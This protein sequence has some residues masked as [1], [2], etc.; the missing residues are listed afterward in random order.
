MAGTEEVVIVGGGVIGLSI[1]YA[2]ARDGVS[3]AVLDRR[4]L[5]REASW[6]GA[7]LIP[8]PSEA[9]TASLPPAGLLRAW[10]ATLFPQWS[11]SLREETGIDNGFRKSGGVDVAF[12][13]HEEV[14]IQAVAG[15]WRAEGIVHERLAPQDFLQIEPALNPEIRQVYFLPDRAQIRNPWHLRALSAASSSR[16]VRLLPWHAIDRFET[17]GDRVIKIRTSSGDISCGWVIVA[18]GAWSGRLLGELGIFAPTPPLKGQIVLLRHDRPLVRRIVE[19][20]KNYLVPREDGRV[21]VGATEEDVGFD[22]RPT[23]VA[24]RDL[25]DEALRL[26]P[27]LAQAEV[28]TTWAGLRPGSID[29]RPYIGIA[30]GYRNLIVA[31]GHKRAG[32]QLSPATGELVADLVLGRPS[33]LDLAPFRLDREPDAAGDAFRS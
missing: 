4:E 20:G 18:A 22:K 14:A 23:P 15:Q 6:A 26:C 1:A 19:H 27:V 2:L 16:G 3:S 31:A 9:G 29:S 33:R 32:L 13:A 24:I 8:P 17:R 28:E 12:T 30:P 5:G 11:A 10:S 7:G 21:L 25:L